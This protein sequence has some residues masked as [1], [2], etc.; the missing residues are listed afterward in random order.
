MTVFYLKNC[1]IL[2][3]DGACTVSTEESEDH[4]MIMYCLSGKTWALR[5]PYPPGLR[6]WLVLLRLWRPLVVETVCTQSL[7]RASPQTQKCRDVARNVSTAI[8]PH[9]Q[10]RGSNLN[11]VGP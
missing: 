6:S 4:S 7:Q 8:A 9:K 1:I 2:S 5:F 11:E 3:R 10:K